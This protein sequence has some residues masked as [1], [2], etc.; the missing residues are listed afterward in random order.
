MTALVADIGGTKTQLALIDNQG[1]LLARLLVAN[2]D[3]ADFD[4]VIDTFL[5]QQPNPE[6]AVVAVAGPVDDAIRCQMTNLHWLIDGKALQQRL[7]LKNIV[8][9]NDLQATA[10]GMT[11]TEVQQRLEMVRGNHLD[12]SLPVLVISPG[13]GLGEA[14]IIPWQNSYVINATEGGHK[15][16]APFNPLSARLLAQ[17]WQQHNYPPS[18]ENWFSGSGL[19]KLYGALFPDALDGDSIPDNESLGQQALANPDSPAGQCLQLFTQAIYAEAGNLVLQYLAWGGVI[20]AGGIPPKLGDLFRQP[21]NIAYLHHKNEY[22]ERLQA[23]PV[24]LCH[25]TDIPLKGAAT[26]CLNCMM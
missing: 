5:L 15:S 22:I 18:W 8:L 16:I 7:G 3:Y 25:E 19:G 6:Y 1:Q 2:R 23:V 26:Y 20:V 14:C 13:T 24:A 12:F 4:R 10:W 17:H 9:L 11:A 21:E